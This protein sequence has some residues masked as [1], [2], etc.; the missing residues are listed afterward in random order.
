MQEDLATKVMHHPFQCIAGLEQGDRQF[1]LA[2]C[3][4]ELLAYS[5]AGRKVASKWC[6]GITDSVAET[7][8]SHANYSNE[9]PAKKQKIDNKTTSPPSKIISIRSSPD[10]CHVVVV[11]DDKVIYVLNVSPNGAFTEI[12]QRAMPKRPC[13]VRI[14]PD[15][16]TIL[17]GD[18]FGD[19]YSLPLIVSKSKDQS[20]QAEAQEVERTA[21]PA[22]FKPSATPLTVHT[23]R[24]LRA[25]ESQ[26]KQK[27]VTPRKEPLAFEHR[28]LL[29]HV[30]MLTDMIH[31]TREVDGKTRRY[32]LTADR[33]EHIRVS[34]GP[35][36]SHVIEGYCLGHTDFVSKICLI[37]GSDLLVS[38]GGNDWLGVWDW[39]RCELLAKVDLR[40]AISHLPSSVDEKIAV[41]GMWT[42]PVAAQTDRWALCVACEKLPAL[43]FIDCSA[44]G[45]GSPADT[46]VTVFK[47]G[48]A[49]VLDVTYYGAK[50][51]CTLLALD[52]RRFD[53]CR[54]RAVQVNGTVDDGETGSK[55]T[56]S[57]VDTLGEPLLQLS[58]STGT[59]EDNTALD[60]F[61]YTT[62]NLRKRGGWDDENEA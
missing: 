19:V 14:L 47:T 27:I 41:S 56:I 40:K 46:A 25:L 16:S 9:R 37:P 53:G 55:L 5:I 4:V 57:E 24:N 44:L 59:V 39:P 35:P 42:V 30:S 11:T 34:R 51:G 60:S 12:S 32:I 48:E 22:I 61:L 7:V 33:D 13:A 52:D 15:S 31:A 54:V 8:N 21:E 3:G 23:K 45:D 50:A 43:V 29:G 38:G 26:K 18:K 6:S 17:I 1:L 2:A 49:P 58:A 28:L 10:Q 20:A 62:A 36:Q